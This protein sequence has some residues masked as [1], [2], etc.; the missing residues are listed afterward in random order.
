MNKHLVSDITVEESKAFTTLRKAVVSRPERFQFWL[1][2]VPLLRTLLV[3]VIVYVG[4][5]LT[6]ALFYF[7]NELVVTNTEENL[8]LSF[9]ATLYFS[10]SCQLTLSFGEYIPSNSVGQILAAL[11]ALIGTIMFTLITGL[12]VAK[13]LIPPNPIK[14][15]NKLVFNKD[16]GQFSVRYL[17]KSARSLVRIE[18]SISAR[19][20]FEG[21]GGAGNINFVTRPILRSGHYQEFN[22]SGRTFVLSTLPFQNYIEDKDLPDI[23]P[24]APHCETRVKI[25]GW[26]QLPANELANIV[27]QKNPDVTKALQRSA[28]QYLLLTP[29]NLGDFITHINVVLSYTY[30]G[31]FGSGSIATSFQPKIGENILCGKYKKMITRDSNS[32]GILS[33]E[34]SNFDVVEET[35]ITDCEKCYLKENCKI[36]EFRKK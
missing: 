10:A 12:I 7:A 23:Y 35:S 36:L 28:I 15:S 4:L 30:E 6:F 24:Y 25:E 21:T 3:F 26:Q 20:R 17:V 32:G 22:S 33:I 11:Q 5:I 14:T 27:A 18:P 8:P 31:F 16:T 29:A 13:L 2:E 19:C 1:L 9:L 34:P